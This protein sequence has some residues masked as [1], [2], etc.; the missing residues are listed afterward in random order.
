MKKFSTLE[1]L[2]MFFVMALTMFSIISSAIQTFIAGGW[3]FGLLYTLT[4]VADGILFAKIAQ[5]IDKYDTY[6]LG[7][8]ASK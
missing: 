3:G 7:K 2:L 5:A 4:G 1:K 8:Q 6:L